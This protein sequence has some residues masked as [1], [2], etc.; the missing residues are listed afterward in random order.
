MSRF[1]DAFGASYIH[2]DVTAAEKLLAAM[3]TD[4]RLTGP[5]EGVH[6]AEAVRRFF[7]SPPEPLRDA[8][9][10]H[11]LEPNHQGCGHLRLL[12]T[13]EAEYGV[14][15]GLA[16]SFLRHFFESRWSGA[17]ECEHV[18]LAG[19]HDEK[20]VLVIRID[21]EIFPFTQIPLVSP[22]CHNSQMFVSHPQVASYYRGQLAEFI[23]RL[24][25]V[26]RAPEGI[27]A[28]IRARS[29]EL[30]ERQT[31]AT[32]SR[33]AAGLPIFEVTSGLDGRV[34]VGYRG[35]VPGREG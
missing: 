35:A 10:T 11:M 6:G 16:D 24:P 12:P 20:G 4:P 7:A 25:D 28:R 23:C 8:V 29:D 9:L 17:D 3:R 34:D 27:A 14:R 30:A 33:L 21:T 13:N 32:L 5:L 22:M 26:F 1:P 19:E 18:V 15:R 2:T 31:G